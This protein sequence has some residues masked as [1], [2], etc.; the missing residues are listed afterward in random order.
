MVRINDLKNFIEISVF[1]SLSLAAKKLEVTQPALSESIKRLE[2]DI[3]KK[4]FYRTKNGISLTPDGRKVL[5]KAKLTLESLHSLIDKNS[6]TERTS[7]V[8]G[9][10][11]IIGTYFLPE[12]LKLAD[13]VLPGYKIQLTHDLSR[14][15]Q[16][17]VQ[18]GVI[19]LGVVV[20]PF[21]HP[22]LIIKPIALD[23]ICVW[24]SKKYTPQ[25]Q[26]LADPNLFQVQ[27]ILKKWIKAPSNFISTN[28]LELIARIVEQGGGYG[29]IPERIVK[30]LKLDLVQVAQTP[31]FKDQISLVYRPEFGKSDYEKDI[32]NL[33]LKCL[34]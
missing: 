2:T 32:I 27:S 5:E 23:R 21:S 33:I 25:N 31:T 18:N 9:C 14:N 10:H 4:L 28:S 11:S 1:S 22:D 34:S 17:G 30:L 20:N 13:K 12:F 29:I 16:M 26:V 24:K 6:A 8:I 7:V 3:G 15:I 19:D